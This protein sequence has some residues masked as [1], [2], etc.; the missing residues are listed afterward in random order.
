MWIWQVG[1]LTP[2]PQEK[3]TGKPLQSIFPAE[4]GLLHCVLRFLL[5]TFGRE[6]LHLIAFLR[7]VAVT[8]VGGERKK[9]NS[10]CTELCL[11]KWQ[12]I[13]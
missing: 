3:S 8:C 11:I 13:Y 9:R 6:N 2:A 4:L 12:F 1:V 7:L 10:W 5:L